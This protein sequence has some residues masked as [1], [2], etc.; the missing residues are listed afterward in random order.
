MSP[1]RILPGIRL[2]REMVN[3]SSPSVGANA[4]QSGGW[5]LLRHILSSRMMFDD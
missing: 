5:L 1:G 3:A 4:G 2:D